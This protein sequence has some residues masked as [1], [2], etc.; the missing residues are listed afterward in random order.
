MDDREDPTKVTIPRKKYEDLNQAA[1][2]WEVLERYGVDNWDGYEE[3]MQE[4]ATEGGG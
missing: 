2:K 4:L 3:A 1:A